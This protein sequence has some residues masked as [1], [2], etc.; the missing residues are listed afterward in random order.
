LALV[1][2]SDALTYRFTFSFETN[3]FFEPA[4]DNEPQIEI[5]LYRRKIPFIEFLNHI[6]LLFYTSDLSLIDGWSIFNAPPDTLSPFDEG[7]LEPVD[8]DEAG[9]DITAEI[10]G[11][12]RVVLF[13]RSVQVGQSRQAGQVG[14]RA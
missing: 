9:V 5:E 2:S 13:R 7:L 14:N 10:D 12:G 4:T 8:W 1:L 11:G 6:P 3:K